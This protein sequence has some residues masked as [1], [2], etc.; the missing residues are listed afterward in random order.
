MAGR[1]QGAKDLAIKWDAGMGF[2]VPGT[3]MVKCNNIEQMMEVGGMGSIFICVRLLNY[4]SRK[5]FRGCL[6]TSSNS[7]RLLWDARLCSPSGGVR[8]EKTHGSTCYRAMACTY[9]K[10]VFSNNRIACPHAPMQVIR[11]GMQ[12]RHVGSHELNME[13]SRSHSLMTIH[14]TGACSMDR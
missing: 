8:G 13:S 4:E 6:S 2:H 14:C 10:N 5:G 11:M 7:S 12:H 3:K 9:L 1:P